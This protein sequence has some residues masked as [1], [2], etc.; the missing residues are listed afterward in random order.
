[1]VSSAVLPV[2]A[3]DEIARSVV[4]TLNLGKNVS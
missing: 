1:M 3:G 4:G 2:T